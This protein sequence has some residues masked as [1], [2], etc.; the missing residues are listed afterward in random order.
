MVWEARDPSGSLKI[1]AQADDPSK[2]IRM[3][4][5]RCTE[6]LKD[7]AGSFSRESSLLGRIPVRASILRLITEL[8]FSSCLA[9]DCHVTSCLSFPFSGLRFPICEALEVFQPRG[10]DSRHLQHEEILRQASLVA[11]LEKPS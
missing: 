4:R 7:G 1:A 5:E 11:Q 6:S 3:G 9:S 2:G 10:L 8:G